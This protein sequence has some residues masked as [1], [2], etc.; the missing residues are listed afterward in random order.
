LPIVVIRQGVGRS[1]GCSAGLLAVGIV[2]VAVVQ[3]TG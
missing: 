1:G 2:A 3:S